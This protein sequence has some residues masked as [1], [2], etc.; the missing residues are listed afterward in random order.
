M[1]GKEATILVTIN[2]N[3]EEYTKDGKFGY[4]VDEL[5]SGLIV[6]LQQHQMKI[7]DKICIFNADKLSK[8]EIIQHKHQFQAILKE[9]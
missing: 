1:E 8:K 4:T 3:E 7:T 9:D 2:G 6:V 5:I